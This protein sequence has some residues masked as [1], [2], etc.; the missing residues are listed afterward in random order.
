M[1][2]LFLIFYLLFF[3][4][5]GLELKDFVYSAHAI[6]I[7]KVIF[8]KTKITKIFELFDYLCKLVNIRISKHETY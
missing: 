1:K 4:G 2:R 3:W 6:D 8:K 5:G 7:I